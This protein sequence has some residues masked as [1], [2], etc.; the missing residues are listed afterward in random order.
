MSETS[1]FVH[2]LL[3]KRTDG[4]T[5]FNSRSWV[6]V[7]KG[8]YYLP[9]TFFLFTKHYQNIRGIDGGLAWTIMIARSLNHVAPLYVLS[10]SPYLNNT[11]YQ[12]NGLEQYMLPSERTCSILL[13]YQKPFS[14]EFLRECYGEELVELMAKATALIHSDGTYPIRHAL[15]NAAKTG[16][17]LRHIT[18]IN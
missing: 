16:S 3:R 12:V 8:Y 10:S 2:P 9:D 11:C 18:N 6:V 5:K 7:P 4:H 15:S 1:I 17:R 14:E 13:E